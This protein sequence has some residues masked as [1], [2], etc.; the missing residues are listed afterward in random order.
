M[1]AACVLALM[2]TALSFFSGGFFDQPRLVAGIVAWLAIAALALA[3][4]S[5]TPRGTGETLV[6]TGLGGLAIW[7]AASIAWA[8]LADGA[9][10]DAQRVALYL[11]VLVLALALFRAPHA[12]GLAEPLLAAGAVAVIGYGL[13]GRL[14]PGIVDPELGDQALGRLDQPL[15]YWNA[16][17]AVAALGLVLCASLA[18]RQRDPEAGGRWGP[19][20]AAGACVPLGAGLY[21]TFSRGGLLAAVTG[22]TVLAL[23]ADGTRAV[24]RGPVLAL[25]GGTVGA[26][27]VAFLPAVA[28]PRNGPDTV[29]GL[30][31]LALI[32]AGVAGIGGA[33][34]ALGRGGA[35][36]TPSAGR[37]S[38]RPKLGV[39]LALAV[40]LVGGGLAG[41]AW[42]GGDHVADD[43]AQGATAQRLRSV[44]SERYA[45]WRVALG[46]FADSPLY[47]QGAR[48][49]E[50]E[51]RREQPK[52]SAPASDAHSLYLETAAELG[53]IGLLALAAMLA[54][55][56]LVA[57]AAL[58]ASSVAAAGPIAGL[59]AWAVH[60][61]LDWDW[62]MPAVSL[63]AILL[64]CM[65][66]AMASAATVAQG[67]RSGSGFYWRRMYAAVKSAT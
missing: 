36:P 27:A 41:F 12:T 30:V 46:A 38:A 6:V 64:V 9:L 28:D 26:L 24:L 51:W 16:V 23:L 56:V 29:Q 3:G 8:P 61:G 11:G 25:A 55:F 42:I 2:P 54:G 67:P 45:Y 17:G 50:V 21:L 65:L 7:T 52:R 59:V 66:A 60:A 44:E 31:G 39:A 10:D 18:A 19:V 33:Y 40:V 62:E 58:K 15:T 34:L 48:G 4:V 35:A 47:G 63:I 57:M 5:L 14:L 53:I 20:A 1:V 43:P 49:F 32:G 13:L 37:R 22:L